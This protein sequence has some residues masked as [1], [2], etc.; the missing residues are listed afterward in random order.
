MAEREGTEQ[1]R[2]T[3]E[4]RLALEEQVVA[5]DETAGAWSGQ[6][7]REMATCKDIGRRLAD[8]GRS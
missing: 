1:Q 6:N 5:L 7:H 2:A 3:L 8:M 4:E